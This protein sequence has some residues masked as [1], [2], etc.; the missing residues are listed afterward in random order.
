MIMMML[1]M[2]VM[3]LTMMI[4]TMT[5]SLVQGHRRRAVASTVA[6]AR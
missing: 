3:M 6:L 1:M 4:M 2:L 5:P